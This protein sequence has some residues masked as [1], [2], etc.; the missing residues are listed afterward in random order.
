MRY[1]G[2]LRMAGQAGFSSIV[3][4]C[5]SIF[6]FALCAVVVVLL[7]ASCAIGSD[8]PWSKSKIAEYI[9]KTHAISG[10]SVGDDPLTVPSEDD[11]K[12]KD[13][14]WTVT[15]ADGT[16]FMVR[17]H[18]Y[19]SNAAFSSKRQ[20]RDNY[21]SVHVKKYLQQ[22]DYSG[23]TLHGSADNFY[24]GIWL[25][26]R[27][28]NRQE[29]RR[30]VDR[31]NVLSENC[32]SGA[33]IPYWLKY[34][35]PFRSPQNDNKYE[36]GDTLARGENDWLKAGEKLS[37]D[38]CERN[39]LEVLVDMR[40]EPSLHDFTDAEIHSFVEGNCWSF[41]VTQSDGS[42]KVYDDL[43]LAHGSNGL[44]FATA[45]EVMKRE[46]YLV[47]G[48]P[49]RYSFKGLD[50]SRYEFSNSFIENGSCYFIKDG[51]HL[52]MENKNVRPG[53][54]C[55]HLSLERFKELTGIECVYYG[56]IQQSHIGY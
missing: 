23:F 26:G 12:F 49:S 50:G 29:L 31:L 30:L 45:Y 32:P 4:C 46:G 33:A 19:D 47:S 43:L 51:Q 14:T 20:I 37:Y 52:P 48:T 24:D 13:C 17:D 36:F 6:A 41:G 25:E 18:Y 40:Y 27:F 15:E 54:Y 5:V 53:D 2:L 10:F 7:W 55:N 22:A 3:I 38:K 21:N 1:H 39:M 34:M 11:P 8:K 16:I 28:T 42:Y 9:E 35:H 44:S 56:K